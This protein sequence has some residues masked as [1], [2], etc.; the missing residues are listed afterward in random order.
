MNYENL[1]YQELAKLGLWKDK[2]GQILNI[3]RLSNSYLHNIQNYC[4]KILAEY[5]AE[6]FEY[7]SEPTPK[8][9]KDWLELDLLC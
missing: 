7:R 8:W 6:E 3:S 9:L 5:I 1:S 4:P 2:S